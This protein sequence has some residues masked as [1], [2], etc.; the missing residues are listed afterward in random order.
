MAA[1]LELAKRLGPGGADAV[2]PPTDPT[3]DRA[4][5]ATAGAGEDGPADGDHRDRGDRHG[6]PRP[7]PAATKE[8]TDAILAE[9]DALSGSPRSRPRSAG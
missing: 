5:P 6:P 9:L 4:A 3:A 7:P 1:V 8:S 2:P